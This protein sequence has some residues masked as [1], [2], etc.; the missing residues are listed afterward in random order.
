VK[1]DPEILGVTRNIHILNRS[2]IILLR[3][4]SSA[5]CLTQLYQRYQA[6]I[7]FR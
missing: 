1:D 5:L 7:K 3:S 4:I 6:E 2:L